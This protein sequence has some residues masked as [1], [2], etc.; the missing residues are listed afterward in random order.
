MAKG[1]HHT[2]QRRKQRKKEKIANGTSINACKVCMI[3]MSISSTNRNSFPQ[4]ETRKED[5]VKTR[6]VLFNLHILIA[7]GRTYRLDNY[8]NHTPPPPPPRKWDERNKYLVYLSIDRQKKN[9][10]SSS[11]P[12]FFV[13]WRRKRTTLRHAVMGL[14][15]TRMYVLF[16]T[17]KGER[18]TGVRMTLIVI[19]DSWHTFHWMGTESRRARRYPC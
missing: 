6:R 8:H 4:T 19:G 15:I 7:I 2:V 17:H 13:P 9:T 14:F 3:H 1:Y 16:L 12:S 5:E 10:L 11:C 18:E